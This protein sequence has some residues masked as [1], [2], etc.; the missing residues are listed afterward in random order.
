MK[1]ARFILVSALE[2]ELAHTMLFEDADSVEEAL[3]K[4][5]AIVG[6]NAKILLMP[7][8]GLTVPLLKK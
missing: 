7:Q 2:K 8:G 6:E 3:A 4:A 5:E 1:K